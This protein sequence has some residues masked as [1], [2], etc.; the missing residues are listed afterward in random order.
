MD[1]TRGAVPSKLLLAGYSRAIAAKNSREKNRRIIAELE[2][3]K[4]KYLTATFYLNSSNP[5]VN[6]PDV[7]GAVFDERGDERRGNPEKFISRQELIPLYILSLANMTRTSKSR[8]YDVQLLRDNIV[9]KT[10]GDNDYSI[11]Y[12]IGFYFLNSLRVEIPNFVQTYEMFHCGTSDEVCGTGSQDQ[13]LA[14]E[15]VKGKSS[16][17][18]IRNLGYEDMCLLLLQVYLSL[19]V[20]NKRFG[21][22]HFDLHN[23][24]VLVYDVDPMA[25]TYNIGLGDSMDSVTIVV[26]FVAVLLDF[27]M[28]KVE[29]HG[30]DLCDNCKDGNRLY[31]DFYAFLESCGKKIDD[32]TLKRRL[33]GILDMIPSIYQSHDIRGTE[34]SKPVIE[35]LLQDCTKH[36][37]V[38]TYTP[39]FCKRKIRTTPVTST[40]DYYESYP[41]SKNR[42]V[43]VE[44]V[45]DLA[46][47]Q[48]DKVQEDRTFTT[49][50]KLYVF[51]YERHRGRITNPA[52]ETRYQQC[53]SYILQEAP[54]EALERERMLEE[55]RQ[56]EKRRME[57]DDM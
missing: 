34:F 9:I 44:E 5:I 20:A 38:T 8:V 15:K 45:L 21:F 42:R 43:D 3:S 18:F 31:V 46:I 19:L 53:L 35:R 56:Y 41:F 12:A 25:I 36:N 39:S 29:Y 33:Q 51:F 48:L 6:C 57:L 26:P 30:E 2:K 1:A 55:R 10:S 11:E 54:S 50:C 40:L 52:H 27:G 37:A 23:E 13:F 16:G 32:T 49:Y 17:V 7:I 28:S 4:S 14:L 24:N 47:S 22:C